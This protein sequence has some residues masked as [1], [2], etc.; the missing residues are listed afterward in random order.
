MPL[1]LAPKINSTMERV[2][3]S[4]RNNQ[5][6][7]Q[8]WLKSLETGLEFPLYSSVDIR[9]SGFK[10]VVVDTNLF[11]E[12]YIN[13]C[14]HGLQDAVNF[15]QIAIRKRLKECQSILILIEEH[16]RN[17]WYLESVRILLNIFSKGGFNVK[18]ATFLEHGVDLPE[19][20]TYIERE[21]AAGQKVR[22]Y[23]F[24][25]MMDKHDAGIEKFD[26]IVLSNDLINGVP[27][28]LKNTKIP[29]YPSFAVGW[30]SRKKSGHFHFANELVANFANL[31]QADPWLFSSLYTF[32]DHISVEEESN[33]LQLYEAANDLLI[34][35][36]KKYN[37]HQ[38]NEKPYIVIKADASAYGMG[39]MMAEDVSQ[40]LTMKHKERKKISK[41]KGSEKIHRYL[42]QEGVPTAYHVHNQAAEVCLYQIEENFIGAFYRSNSLKGEKGNLNSKGME[43]IKICS[44][45]DH[46]GDET[47][48]PQDEM[49]ELYRILGQIAAIA[50]HKETLHL[51]GELV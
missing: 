11:P 32:V 31:I 8:S 47:A 2:L 6:E 10:T 20:I 15:F 51:K 12:G 18:L 17:I 9:Y 37:E 27:E 36:Q 33:R 42:I 40:L 38:I 44:H 4:I 22:I 29:I 39:V 30:H 41:G 28:I 5:K 34:K 46:Q 48:Y 23:C 49:F 19:K 14:Q 21:T 7:I 50:A 26:L 16:S 13:L 24:K 25:E 3:Q 45:Q 35:V 1:P 43:F